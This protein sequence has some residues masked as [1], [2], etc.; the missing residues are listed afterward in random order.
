MKRSTCVSCTMSSVADSSRTTCAPSMPAWPGAVSQR[1]SCASGSC[2]CSSATS[3]SG[4]RNLSLTKTARF[5]PMRSLLRGMMA[6]WRAMNGTGMR[7]NSATTANQSAIAPTIAASAMA[8]RMSTPKLGG[9]QLVTTNT[10]VTSSSR[11]SAWRL[12]RANSKCLSIRNNPL[13]IKGTTDW[14]PRA[15]PRLT[16]DL[17]R[18]HPVQRRGQ[19]RHG[20][21]NVVPLLQAEEPD[22]EG[23]EI[24]PFVALQ[25]HAGSGLQA[26]VDELLAASDAGVG[27]VAHHD[28]GR[29]VAICRDTGKAARF[30]QR[31]HP[32]AEFD[33][34]DPDLVETVIARL[35][36]DL[37]QIDQGVGRHRGVVAVFALF[38]AFGD[39]Q[40]LLEVA[41][42]AGAARALDRLASAHAQHDHGAAG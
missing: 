1:A 4:S 8:L 6:V 3:E 35:A 36:H 33:L 5:S 16:P 17:T 31:A 27:R 2:R 32:G 22:A 25:R 38:V 26:G 23:A 15:V 7:R 9:S 24:G 29:L 14:P 28:T 39:L 12:E 41:R 13:R 19:L 30:E 10:A 37:P 42:E 18:C 34:L 40:P 11:P 21:I 20:A